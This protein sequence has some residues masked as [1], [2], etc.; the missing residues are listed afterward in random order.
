[1]V[2]VQSDESGDL[3]DLVDLCGVGYNDPVEDYRIRGT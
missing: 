2:F 1:M 3:V